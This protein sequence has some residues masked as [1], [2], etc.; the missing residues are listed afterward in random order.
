ML[1][2][3][4]AAQLYTIRSMINSDFAGTVGKVAAIGYRPVELAGY[5]NLSS[6][7]GG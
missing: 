4:I 6:A 1:Q 5:V 2:L 7:R 3:R